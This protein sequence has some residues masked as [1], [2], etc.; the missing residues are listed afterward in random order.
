MFLFWTQL[1]AHT[2]TYPNGLKI[3]RRVKEL[4]TNVREV[5]G[6]P[7]P[8]ILPEEV[9]AEEAVDFV[10]VGEGEATMAELVDHL[11]SGEGDLARIKGLGYK[12]GRELHVNE[13]REP[14]DPDSLPWPARDLFP[15]DFYQDRW[16]VLTARGGCP[17]KCPFCSASFL[18]QGHRRPRAPRLIVDEVRMLM[19]EY[20][21]GYVFFSDDI[22]TL[23]RKWVHELL[24]LLT[25]LPYPLEWGCA[26]LVDA[27]DRTLLEEMARAGC[28]AIQYGIESGSQEI[29]DSVKHIQKGQA[30]EAVQAAVGAGIEVACSFMVAFPEDTR[31]TIRETAAFM[32]RLS[33]LGGRILLSYTTPYPGT[34]SYQ[35]AQELGLKIL[36]D[37]WEEFDAKY[38]VLET[39]H[40]SAAEIDAQVEKVAAELG[41]RRG[42]P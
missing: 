28:R 20:V 10:V 33:D 3:V 18:W 32:K 35:H 27:V 2:E 34:H 5:F 16:N 29:L 1:S 15:L 41:L 30:V 14:L 36:A 8:S 22:F 25:E 31:E 17:F 12:R 39:K 42:I 11:G 7:H 38:N 24:G 6:G 4:H 21:A 37:G 13:R 19:E 23:N 40:L 26:T 9:L